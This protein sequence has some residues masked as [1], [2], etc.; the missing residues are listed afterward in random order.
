[1]NL[2][3]WRRFI[4]SMLWC[5]WT[6]PNALRQNRKNVGVFSK[7]LPRF[8]RNLPRFLKK[9][10]YFLRDFRRRCWVRLSVFLCFGVSF[11]SG[12]LKE[13]YK[14]GLSFSL[15][16]DYRE[17]CEG[18]E[19]KKTWFSVTRA[20]GMAI[21]HDFVAVQRLLTMMVRGWCSSCDKEIMKEDRTNACCHR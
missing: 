17:N 5:F 1:M 7:N 14:I 13:C 2:S 9:L 11:G 20:R 16:D 15:S 18:C 6:F 12:S 4:V 19:S 21:Q 8:S 10:G 3:L